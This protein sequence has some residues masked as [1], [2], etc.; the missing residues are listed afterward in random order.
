TLWDQSFITAA[1]FKAAA[2]G[3]VLAGTAFEWGNR[4]KYNTQWR[5]L[6]VGIGAEH[7]EARAVRI[8][9][10]TGTRQEI[11]AFFND[12]CTFIEVDLA[13]GSCVYRDERT[14]A[15]TFP[16]ERFDRLGSVDDQTAKK[17]RTA[18]E[19]HVDFLAKEQYG[20]ETPPIVQ[21]SCKSTRSFIAMSRELDKARQVLEVPVHRPWAIESDGSNGRHVCPVTLV[22]PGHPSK[23]GNDRKQDVSKKA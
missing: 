18:I 9:D 12:V 22:R 21:L 11:A 20:F 14:L 10:W 8:G 23:H 16:G 13:L 1:L 6:T 15:F 7:Y 19:A 3:A 17:L 4:V 2:A 5:V